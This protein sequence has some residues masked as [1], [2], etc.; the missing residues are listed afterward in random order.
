MTV[1]E[2]TQ[3]ILLLTARFADWRGD[4][5]DPLTPA[6]WGRFAAWLKVRRLQP[7]DLLGGPPSD[8]LEGW[9][10]SRVTIPRVE[11]L[12]ARGPALALAMDRWLGS[13]L[14][15][16]TRA[17]PAYPSRL[18]TRLGR[19]SPPVL[20]GCG[21]RE[22]PDAGGIA[23]VGS[24][25]APPADRAY[26]REVGVGAARQ[27]HAV[28]S[29]GAR[30]VDEA[31]MLGALESGGTA[32]GVVANGLL[33]R[34]SSASYRRHLIAGD[35]ALVSATHPEARLLASN[36]LQRN[37]YIY[38]LADAAVAVRS[39]TAGGTWN[40]AVE[41]LRRGWVPLWVKPTEDAAPGNAALAGLGAR[42]APLQAAD[43]RMEE[44]C[45][46]A[47]LPH[48]PTLFPELA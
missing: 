5:P 45:E 32:V 42:W 15:V 21:N 44:L 7:A 37:H 16:M 8:L 25:D 36:A 38:C 3:A 46:R 4:S 43:I 18:K 12:L 10:D 2:G 29:G 13:G 28:I 31:A 17:D 39:A 34:C 9:S 20:F 47:A 40:S 24:P 6:E 1:S 26:S 27:G 23:V 35:L 19:N 30:G 33:G 14:W 41:N 22:L 48:T 11:R